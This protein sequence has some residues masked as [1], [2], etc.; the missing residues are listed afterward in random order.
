MHTRYMNNPWE[1]PTGRGFVQRAPL[2][3]GPETPARRSEHRRC[4]PIF[5]TAGHFQPMADPD[6]GN[7]PVESAVVK[8]VEDKVAI[9]RRNG[10]PAATVGANVKLI[11]TMDRRRNGW[12]CR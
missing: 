1:N 7:A 11:V 2:I 3:V 12:R 4:A 9:F 8:L 10:L 6:H 5:T